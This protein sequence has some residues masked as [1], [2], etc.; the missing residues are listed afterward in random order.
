MKNNLNPI[1][2]L[3]GLA[4][5]FIITF[6]L[7]LIVALLLRFTSIR[8][9]NINLFNNF[10]LTISIV[11]SSVVLARK[12]REKGWLN[13]AILGFLYYFIIILLNLIFNRPL[14]LGIFL[15]IRLLIATAFG[16]IGGMIGINLP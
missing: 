8:E 3:R 4:L 13:G 14:D 5:A 12:I 7:L 9:T 10:V 6:I 16:A 2:W 11:V 15:L 1:N